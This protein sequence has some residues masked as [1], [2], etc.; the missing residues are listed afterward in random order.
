MRLPRTAQHPRSNWRRYDLESQGRIL[1]HIARLTEDGT[2]RPS[3]V[4]VRKE[5]SVA[6]LREMHAL[7]GSGK[8]YGKIAFTV[9]DTIQ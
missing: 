4:T 2:L 3:Q 6:N 8:A 5:F 1:A 7:Q 9:P